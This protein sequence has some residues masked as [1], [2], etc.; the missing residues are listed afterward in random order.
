[1]ELMKR[2]PARKSFCKIFIVEFF[3]LTKNECTID[4]IPLFDNRN[5]WNY[6]TYVLTKLQKEI[7]SQNS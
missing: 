4:Q 7:H 2:T 6:I 5:E 1:M 3:E